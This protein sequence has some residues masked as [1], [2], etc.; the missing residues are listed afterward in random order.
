MPSPNVDV[1]E[2]SLGEMTVPS[3]RCPLCGMEGGKPVV[4]L[5]YH[6]LSEEKPIWAVVQ[7]GFLH[8]LPG[9]CV[10]RACWLET[11]GVE[12][13]EAEAAFKSI[14]DRGCAGIRW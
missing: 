2:K 13:A 9:K 12:L 10:S 1:S 5:K 3:G 8:D 14:V 4:R 6:I 7:V 11:R